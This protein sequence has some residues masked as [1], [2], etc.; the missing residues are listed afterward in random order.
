EPVR[1]DDGLP[2]AQLGRELLGPQR[3]L[4]RVGREDHDD[5]GPRRRRVRR[6]DGEAGFLGDRAP[7]RAGQE[8]YAH[9]DAGV[10][11]VLRVRVPL[12]AVADDRDLLA[13]DEVQVRV[14]VVEDLCHGFVSSV[15]SVM[16]VTDT[17][18]YSL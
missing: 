16:S 12:R 14:V 17:T 4:R 18:S 1:E 6:L 8:R 10:A 11:K 5:V 9:V 3:R 7:A 15:V 2:G 13:R